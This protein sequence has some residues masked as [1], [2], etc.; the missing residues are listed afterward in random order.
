MEKIEKN[1]K[2]K[3]PKIQGRNLL[4]FLGFFAIVLIN[5][6]LTVVLKLSVFEFFVSV[7][8][9]LFV[10]VLAERSILN[11][12]IGLINVI[13]YIILCFQTKLLG[14]AIFYII[15]A[16]LIIPAFLSWMKSLKKDKEESFKVKSRRLKPYWYL[17]LPVGIGLITYVY[18][19]LLGVMGGE[20]Y[21]WDALSTGVTFVATI[22]SWMR[23][24]EQWVGWIFVYIVSIILWSVAGSVAMIVMSAGCL[25]FS[26][27]GLI[28]WYQDAQTVTINGIN[29][30][31]KRKRKR[32]AMK[33]KLKK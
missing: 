31:N 19:L 9:I 8:G 26:I 5:L 27:K 10:A 16:I 6:I 7:T 13:L 14:E 15:D 20:Y 3:I 18:G 12:G 2:I 28:E 24:R 22:L 21:F 11:F 29:F 32:Q 25:L 30:P 1:S 17:I 23:F 33:D 4:T